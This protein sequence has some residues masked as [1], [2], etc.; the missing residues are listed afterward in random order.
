MIIGI[1][2]S[3]NR[4]GGT[5][6]HLV[7]FL[8]NISPNKDRFQEVHIWSHKEFLNELPNDKWLIKFSF[9]IHIYTSVHLVMESGKLM[10]L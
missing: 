2:A 4:S 3:R 9:A 5:L 10:K 8:E 7:G 1:D 6:A